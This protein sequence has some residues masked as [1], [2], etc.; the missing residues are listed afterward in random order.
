MVKV[1]KGKR[2][3]SA[4]L[5]S[6][7]ALLLI[8]LIILLF[9][10]FKYVHKESNIV[11]LKQ[12]NSS[13]EIYILGT[14][15]E[16]HFNRLLGYSIVAIQNVIDNIKPDLLLLEVDQNTFD[17]YEVIKSPI[18]M[19]PLWC[20]AKEYN[21]AVRGVDWFQVTEDSRSWTT[22]KNRDDHIFENIVNSIG[23]EQIVL[24]ILGSRHRIEQ[25]TRFKNAGW[26]IEI[27]P[28]VHDMFVG[29]SVDEF[30]YPADTQKEIEKQI[31][32]WRTVA[33]DDAIQ[34]TSDGSKG[35]KYWLDHY[36]ELSQSVQE[37]LDDI[38]LKNKVY[39]E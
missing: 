31:E 8:G 5:F 14:V 23:D 27:M 18:E 15:H 7:A 25:T 26:Q 11:L 29:K 32:Y 36:A 38:I 4:V 6:L 10:Y 33:V 21:I 16:Y 37:I 22:D 39:K 3:R 30:V 9:L 28:N 12:E 17:N 20:Y 13:Q 19:I 34:I 24:I 2:I 1:S 35:R